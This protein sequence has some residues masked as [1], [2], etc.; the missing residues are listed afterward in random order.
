MDK[1][2][3]L[4]REQLRLGKYTRAYAD[5]TADQLSGLLWLLGEWSCRVRSDGTLG[6]NKARAGAAIRA[7]RQ[8]HRKPFT[9]E[10]ARALMR[11]AR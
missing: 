2:I 6:A 5:L 8:F 11:N 10:E 3:T 1:T 7:L 4:E 9:R